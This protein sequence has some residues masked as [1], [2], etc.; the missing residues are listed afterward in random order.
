MAKVVVLILAFFSFISILG[1]HAPAQKRAPQISLVETGEFHGDEVSAKSGERWLGLFPTAAGFTLL[2]TTLKVEAV[3]DSVVDQKPGIKTGKKVSVS[4]TREPVFLLRG[5]AGMLS[6]GAVTAVF[7]GRE[8]LGNGEVV[9]LKLGN[10]NY[11]LRVISNDPTPADYLAQNSKLLLTAGAK[12]QVLFSVAEHA[13]ASWALL[14]AGDL[15]GDGQL[16]LYMDLN[17]HY[18]SSQRRLFLSTRASRGKLVKEVAEFST[19]GC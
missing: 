8:S 1:N 9:N 16:D 19:V 3:H 18:N 7:S 17:T 15:D 10:N 5:A 6:R 2:P 11:R 12:S 13:D 14:W 4:H